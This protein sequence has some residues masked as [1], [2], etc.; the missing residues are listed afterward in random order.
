M[1]YQEH[2]FADPATAYGDPRPINTDPREQPGF[3]PPTLNT[4]P[5]EQQ[6]WQPMPGMARPPQRGRS[7]WAWVGISVVILVVIFGG[8]A[9][10]SVLLTHQVSATKTFAVG[11]QP[12]LVLTTSSGDVHI[13]SGA[14]NQ[15]SVV[16]HMQ[17]FLGDNSPIPVQYNLSSDGNTLTV[18]ADER[19]GFTFGFSFNRGVDLDVTV[20]S[21]T[22]LNVRDSSGDITS[23]GV[24]GQMSL[25]TSSGDVTT[26][27]GSG[28]VSLTTSSGDI[29]A[30]NISGE[31]TL[32]TSS[33]DVTADNAS[34]SGN[35]SFQT[36][37]GDITYRGSL[38]ANGN[39]SFQDSSGDI[40]LT[41]PGDATFQV[42]QAST[43]SGDI[44]SD[45]LGVNIL[46]N[47]SDSGAIASGF[48]GNAP[49]AKITLRTS[50][51]DIHLHKV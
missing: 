49:Y 42:V 15:I 41:L 48:V 9:T 44:D 24:T 16:A 20:P 46:H 19:D 21:Q 39:Y 23:Q 28:H 31:M 43:D 17:V 10:A 4:D 34:A 27:G 26:D 36:S 29:K 5:R 2:H 8:L 37:S 38:A 11:A 12:K 35:S 1:N 14:A 33:G 40:D 13:V 7:P 22:A 45:F 47:S 32:S 3:R 30:S 50:S 25:T 51:G 6:Y 18:N